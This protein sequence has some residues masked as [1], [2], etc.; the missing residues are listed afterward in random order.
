MS[1]TMKLALTGVLIMSLVLSFGFSQYEADAAN[2]SQKTINILVLLNGKNASGS[3]CTVLTNA[4]P[5]A[6]KTT[7]GKNGQAS[8]TVPSTATSAD[9]TCTLNSYT[10][11]GTFQ[12]T[13]QTTSV[14][15]Y[16]K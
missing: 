14:I 15:I 16:L 9:I 5:I 1:G 3:A 2:S 7:T 11:Q 10:G 6:I 8:V 4:S 12:L 13:Q